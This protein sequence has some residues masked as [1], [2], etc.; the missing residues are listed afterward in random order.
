MLT[1]RERSIH[2]SPNDPGDLIEHAGPQRENFH[3]SEPEFADFLNRRVNLR[4]R[5]SALHEDELATRVQQGSGERDEL[6]KSTHRARGHL[7]EW[8]RQAGILRTIAHDGHVRQPEVVDLLGQ[9]GNSALH[10]FDKCEGHIG[11]GYR[12]HE[13]RQSC[14]AADISDNSRPEKRC[15]DR[16]VQDVPAPEPGELERSDQTPLFALLSEIGGE[17]ARELQLCTEKRGRG[18]G[19]RLDWGRQCFT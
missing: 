17:T 6:A 13:P 2:C 19:L 15:D 7:I 3:I 10:R 8:R 11:S 9:P 12:K 18:S 4:A 14:A 5:A 1:S 16:T